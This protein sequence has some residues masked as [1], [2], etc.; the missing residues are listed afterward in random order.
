MFAFEKFWILEGL[1]VHGNSQYV[2]R[3]FGY[4]KAYGWF[5]RDVSLGQTN[6]R[7]SCDGW[8]WGVGWERNFEH[9]KFKYI[10][11]RYHRNILEKFSD[12]FKYF[13]YNENF[14]RKVLWRS[15]DDESE[16]DDAF[17]GEYARWC[18]GGDQD[19]N[20]N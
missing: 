6:D 4:F 9:S 19:E 13:S 8:A 5:A 12:S 17:D 20:K 16:D 7:D 3:K 10:A 11:R 1:G 2:V 15:D 18:W 14:K